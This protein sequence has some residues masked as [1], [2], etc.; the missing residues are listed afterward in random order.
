MELIL[1]TGLSGAGKSKALEI[2]EDIG[3]YCVDNMPPVLIPKF[4]EMCFQSQGKIEKVALVTDVRGGNFFNQLL[5]NLNTLEDSGYQYK[6]LFLDANVNT[7]IKRYKETR[8]KHPLSQDGQVGILEA[9]TIEERMLK[10]IKERADYI[11]DT[12]NLSPHQ[13]REQIIRI[14]INRTEKGKGMVIDVRSFGFKYGIPIESDL[15]FDVRFLPNPF[16][17]D[18]LQHKTGLDQAV[19][20]YVFKWSQTKEF[21]EKLIDMIR[22]LIP[23]YIEEG[24]TSLVISIG[25]TGGKHRSVSMARRLSELLEKDNYYVVTTHRDLKL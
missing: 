22:F 6:I 23:H 3:F 14:F 20:D 7:L 4:A 25:C 17:I 16:Y 2:L 13:L 8:R 9:I 15:V 21:E 18:E 12:T 19:Y 1:V 24:K 5:E 11:I 10:A